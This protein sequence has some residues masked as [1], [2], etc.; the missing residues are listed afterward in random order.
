VVGPFIGV[1]IDRLRRHSI[2][3]VADIGRACCLALIPVLASFAI[4]TALLPIAMYA[5]LR[6]LGPDG[7][8]RHVLALTSIFA[9]LVLCHAMMA[10]IYGV[11]AFV[12]TVL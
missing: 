11:C 10:A 8:Q 7:R 6:S 2:L 9:T 1:W 4:T 5:L 3:I 12:L